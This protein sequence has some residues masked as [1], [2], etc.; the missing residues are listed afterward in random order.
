[1][2]QSFK[3]YNRYVGSSLKFSVNIFLVL[4]RCYQSDAFFQ[5]MAAACLFLAGKVEETPKKARD[6]FKTIQAHGLLT[7]S[8]MTAAFGDDPKV[9]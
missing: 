1:M 6:I 2:K 7:E 3:E 9:N 4:L 5:A 8:A